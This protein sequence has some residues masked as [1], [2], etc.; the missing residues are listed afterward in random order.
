MERGD[1]DWEVPSRSVSAPVPGSRTLPRSRKA[2]Q[3]NIAP[4]GG[5][6]LEGAS[7]ASF[8]QVGGMQLLGAAARRKGQGK[9]VGAECRLSLPSGAL[10]PRAM[11]T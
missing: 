3:L 6:L 8:T 11:L 7:D 9:A 5:R 4:R 10:Q 1:S 2:G